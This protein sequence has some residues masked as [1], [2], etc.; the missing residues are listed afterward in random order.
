MTRAFQ[1][2]API[3]CTLS[4]DE[5]RLRLHR[6]RELSTRG[7]ISHTRDDR[8][9][10]LH[11]APWAGAEVRALVDAE[12]ECCA[13]LTFALT[14]ATDGVRLNIVAPAQAVDAGNLL[15]AHFAPQTGADT[16]SEP[17]AE[18]CCGPTSTT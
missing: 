1:S 7:L 3:V 11:F 6:I 12:R 5:M 15:F 13:F 17:T 2:K 14:E 18:T 10:Q 16:V 8:T 4:A 9:L